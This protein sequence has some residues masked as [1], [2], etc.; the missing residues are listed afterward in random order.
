MLRFESFSRFDASTSR[1]KACF[2]AGMRQTV[3]ADEQRVLQHRSVM[4][5]LQVPDLYGYKGDPLQPGSACA[6][7]R[8]ALV[9]GGH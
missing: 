7:A 9:G 4:E 8:A 6:C 3:C 2:N 5:E 1:Y